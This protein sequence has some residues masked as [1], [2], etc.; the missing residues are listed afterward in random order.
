[1]RGSE[2]PGM[3]STGP[4][5]G[6]WQHQERS[7][8]YR[9][10]WAPEGPSGTAREC[11]RCV[12][13]GLVLIL[14][15]PQTHIKLHTLAGRY[16]EKSAPKSSGFRVHSQLAKLYFQVKRKEPLIKGLKR[17]L[18]PRSSIN[19]AIFW[20]MRVKWFQIHR[21]NFPRI[22][23]VLE[24]EREILLWGKYFLGYTIPQIYKKYYKVYQTSSASGLT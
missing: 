3:G 14:A 16:S 12:S 24:N 15:L 5:L 9:A 8:A 11:L 21:L 1:M 23:T 17:F 10:K 7:N 22:Y 20:L 13:D 6:L 18:E 4:I 2:A 19:F